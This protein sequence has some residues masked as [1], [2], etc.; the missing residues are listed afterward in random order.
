MTRIIRDDAW[1][2]DVQVSQPIPPDREIVVDFGGFALTTGG[3]AHDLTEE[4]LE[5]ILIPT[6]SPEGYLGDLLIDADDDDVGRGDFEDHPPPE[7]R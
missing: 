5:A 3:I 6:F 4:N 2:A 1:A 7:D